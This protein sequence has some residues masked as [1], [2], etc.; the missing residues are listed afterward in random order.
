MRRQHSGGGM[1]FAT[2]HAEED[3]EGGVKPSELQAE[4]TLRASGAAAALPLETLNVRQRAC[5][6]E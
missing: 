5:K 3:A 2:D 1:E 4:A 6:Q